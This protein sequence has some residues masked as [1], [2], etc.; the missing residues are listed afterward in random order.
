MA[1][2]VA[3]LDF[4]SDGLVDFFFVNGA[5]LADPMPKRKLPDKSAPRYWNRLY[6]NTGHEKFVDVTEQAG[7]QGNGYGMGV[8]VV[9]STQNCAAGLNRWEGICLLAKGCLVSGSMMGSGRP[10]NLRDRGLIDGIIYW[11]NMKPTSFFIS[12]KV[13]LGATSGRLAITSDLILPRT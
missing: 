6:R 8:A 4:D 9:G 2:G 5:A 13:T 7:L 10:E 1:G 3:C 11:P 12:P